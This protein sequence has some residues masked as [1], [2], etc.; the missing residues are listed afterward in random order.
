M[1]VFCLLS[2]QRRLNAHFSVDEAKGYTLHARNTHTSSIAL[3]HGTT[4]KV[5]NYSLSLHMSSSH[6]PLTLSYQ[7]KVREKKTE[8]GGILCLNPPPSPAFVFSPLCG[9]RSTAVFFNLCDLVKSNNI[10]TCLISGSSYS[11]LHI[12]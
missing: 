8:R 2:S 5:V 9:H 3:S 12:L 10:A 1:S 7:A 11:C 4:K 6:W